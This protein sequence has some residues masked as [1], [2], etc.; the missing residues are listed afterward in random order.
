MR[1]LLNA[2]ADH[3]EV[4]ARL[5]ER[6]FAAAAAHQ[7]LLKLLFEHSISAMP[8][9]NGQQAQMAAQLHIV[10]LL[11]RHCRWDIGISDCITMKPCWICM[12]ASAFN[13]ML[14]CQVSSMADLTSINCC[15]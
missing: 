8:F 6:D 3:V 5:H 12:Q 2:G 7:P 13:N 11:S 14:A 1:C 10:E 4:L 9:S 15:Y